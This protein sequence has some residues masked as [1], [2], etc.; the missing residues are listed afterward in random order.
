[1]DGYLRRGWGSWEPEPK[2]V[3]EAWGCRMQGFGISGLRVWVKC[4]QGCGVEAVVDVAARS[5]TRYMGLS[6]N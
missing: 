1:M 2:Q 6:E 3:V 5:E 4:L